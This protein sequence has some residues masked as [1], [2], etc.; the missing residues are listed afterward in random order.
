MNHTTDELASRVIGAIRDREV[1]PR[2][3]WSFAARNA[4]LLALGVLTIALG[5]LTVATGAFLVADRD[6][7]I[8]LEVGQQKTLFALESL[9]FFWLAALAVLVTATYATLTR[10]RRGYRF[11]PV[12]VL[13]GSVL[14]SLALG[15]ALYVAGA[16]GPTH[17][18]FRAHVPAYD[19][20]VVSRER[21]WTSPQRGLLAGIVAHVTS[22]REFALEDG[23]GVVWRITV[24]EGPADG[25]AP[26]A[27]V[28]AIGTASGDGGF[29][30]ASVWPGLDEVPRM[31]TSAAP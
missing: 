29:V 25:V 5:A 27:R 14:A 4:F 26:G 12:T 21:F 19:R 11:A 6:W 18:Y 30:A 15:S 16:G 9:P 8:Y 13:G 28:R 24:P 10:T 1:S 22:S 20:V 2:P 31:A 23:R 17:E 3:K 7:D